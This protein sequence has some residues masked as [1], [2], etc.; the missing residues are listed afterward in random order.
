MIKTRS[1][2]GPKQGDELLVIP[3]PPFKLK[4]NPTFRRFQPINLMKQFGFLPEH[5]IVEKV[6]GSHDKIVI[7]AVLTEEKVKEYKKGNAKK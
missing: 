4:D 1:T 7:K 3:T 6:Q 2:G 5:I